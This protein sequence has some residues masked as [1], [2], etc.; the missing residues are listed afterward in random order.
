MEK[1]A[2]CVPRFRDAITGFGVDFYDHEFTAPEVPAESRERSFVG[3]LFECCGVYS[4][5]YKNGQ[6]TAYA[7]GCPRCGLP[8]KL[9][10]GSE[11]TSERFFR[12]R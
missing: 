5:V 9:R 4:R 11:G 8:I 10:I 12:A 2:A 7:G 1:R 3:I 6:G